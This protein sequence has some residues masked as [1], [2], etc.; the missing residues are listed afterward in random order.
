M[1]GQPRTVGSGKPSQQI[2]V[3][4]LPEKTKTSYNSFSEAAN[5]KYQS[6]ENFYVFKTKS[7]E[8]I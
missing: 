3:F 8:S 1:K 7:K 2:E 6:I 4:D 5:F